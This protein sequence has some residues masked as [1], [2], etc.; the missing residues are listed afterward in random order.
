MIETEKTLLASGLIALA[1][2]VVFVM[3]KID[4]P[5]RSVILHVPFT[6]QAP[7]NNWDR[8]E[9]CEET[10]ITMANA[11]L[12]GQTVDKLPAMASQAS[13]DLLKKWEQANLGYNADTG[14]DATTRMAQGAF[15]LQ[16]KQIKDFTEQDLK[17]ELIQGHPILLPINARLLGNPKYQ[18]AGPFYHMIVLRGFDDHGIIVN[19]P[20]TDSG[21]GNVYS[22]E[23]LRQAAADWNQADRRMEP[24]R[25]IL[26]VLS[27]GK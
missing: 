15:G 12:N 5:L 4:P 1:L 20:G 22:F 17:R 23:T 19:D 24:S 18:E 6:S 26:L 9:D 7:N 10:S 25:K 21:D 3:S 2:A 27:K 8:N 16:V 13:I 14:A 11:Y